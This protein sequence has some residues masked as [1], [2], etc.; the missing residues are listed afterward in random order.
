MTIG[1]RI[2][3]KRIESQLTQEDLAEKIGSTKQT[4]YKYENNIIASI[5]LEKLALIADALG[6]SPAD[7]LG[8]NTVKIDKSRKAEDGYFNILNDIYQNVTEITS[9]DDEAPSYILEYSNTAKLIL[10]EEKLMD[11]FFIIE[12]TIPKTISFLVDQENQNMVEEFSSRLSLCGATLDEATQLQVRYQTILKKARQDIDLWNRLGEH[13]ID[14]LNSIKNPKFKI[15]KIRTR[16][17]A[18]NY[19]NH[20]WESGSVAAL[21]LEEKKDSYL[22]NFANK[23]KATYP[24]I[25]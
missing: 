5:P 19:L 4:I 18:L 12:N 17:E 6:T 1:E 25:E 24:Y 23:M 3:K 22:I 11:C 20:L 9:D 14:L 21:R 8:W 15:C 10:S 16:E 13:E 2:K 7:L